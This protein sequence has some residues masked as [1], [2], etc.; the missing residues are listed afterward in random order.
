[1]DGTK[2]TERDDNGC[3]MELMKRVGHNPSIEIPDVTNRLMV[4]CLNGL[5]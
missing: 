1:M 3:R 4:D 5:A 2:G